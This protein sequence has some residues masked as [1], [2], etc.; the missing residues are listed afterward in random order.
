[1]RN[2]LSFSFLATFLGALVA[3]LLFL[4]L[5][6]PAEHLENSSSTQAELLVR[7]N[8]SYFDD[9]STTTP[10]SYFYADEGDLYGFSPSYKSQP[11]TSLIT[12]LEIS[13][14]FDWASLDD[15]T[16]LLL[17]VGGTPASSRGRDLF[18]IDD[19]TKR[20]EILGNNVQQATFSPSMDLIAIEYLQGRRPAISITTLNGDQIAQLE[21]AT[22]QWDPSG[23]N[24]FFTKTPPEHDGFVTQLA[25]YNIRQGTERVLT[26]DERDFLPLPHPSG[27]WILFLSGS[28][29]G[30]VSFFAMS[31]DGGEVL[32]L[33]NVGEN[34]TSSTSVPSPYRNA[35]WSPDGRFL[36][37]ESREAID[38]PSTIW[39]LEFEEATTERSIPKLT[40]A[41]LTTFG[42]DP[43][44][45]DERTLIAQDESQAFQVVLP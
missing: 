32:Q 13:R 25:S 3:G 30:Y 10:Y 40:S 28:R 22:P 35:T 31:I 4:A 15:Q 34:L 44:W 24:L 33:T 11:G 42:S 36:A 1:M 7:P 27:S 19:G 17:G 9:N 6:S 21:G 39:L 18:L 5:S 16:L 37:F 38:S 23:T 43:R 14:V 8:A 2:P 29:T 41:M 12:D 26:E 45:L 20:T